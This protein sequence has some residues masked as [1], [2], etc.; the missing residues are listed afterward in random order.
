MFVKYTIFSI[1]DPHALQL[2][3]NETNVFRKKIDSPV[4]GVILSGFG[5]KFASA[6][7]LFPQALLNAIIK[8]R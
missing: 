3:N 5:R 8:V 1:G 7:T 2:S 4:S 6:Y